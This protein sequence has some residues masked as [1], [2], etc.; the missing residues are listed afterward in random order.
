MLTFYRNR[1]KANEL[2]PTIDILDENAD[3]FKLCSAVIAAGFYPNVAY[4]DS[5]SHQWMTKDKEN[6]NKKIFV[7]QSSV[8]ALFTQHTRKAGQWL[9][10]KSI[11]DTGYYTVVRDTTLVDVK[12]IVLFSQRLEAEVSDH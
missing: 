3:N 2:C 12:A 1:H 6:K 5:R 11:Q 8:N 10:Y 7:H 9:V 4:Y